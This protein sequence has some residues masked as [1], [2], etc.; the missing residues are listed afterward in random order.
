MVL[1]HLGADE[2]D[3]RQI[4]VDGPRLVELGPQIDEHEIAGADD[5]VLA[6]RRTVMRI[7]AVLVHGTDGRMIGLQLVGLE[8]IE[9]DLLHFGLAHLRRRCWQR[10]AMK[11]KATS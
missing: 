4:A 10:W 11:P 8:M 9:D 6:G 1:R 3:A 7:A 5:A 2:G